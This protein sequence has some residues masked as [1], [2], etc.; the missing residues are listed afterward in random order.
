M[1]YLLMHSNNNEKY[2]FLYDYDCC[3][4]IYN[5]IYNIFSNYPHSYY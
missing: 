4:I 2:R 5:I 1:Y 3:N